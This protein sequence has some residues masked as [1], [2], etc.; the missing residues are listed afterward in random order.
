MILIYEC[1][2]LKYKKFNSLKININ[3][4]K[5]NFPNVYITEIEIPQNIFCVLKIKKMLKSS[6]Y[7]HMTLLDLNQKKNNYN[8]L[9]KNLIPAL[10]NISK[11]YG[12]DLNNTEIGIIIIEYN[13]DVYEMIEKVSKICRCIKIHENNSCNF[14]YD[15][16]CLKTGTCVTKG[17]KD[18]KIIINIDE[19]ISIITKSKTYFD[20]KLI[21]NNEK[22]GLNKELFDL[23]FCYFSK[24]NDVQE[25]INKKIVKKMVLMSK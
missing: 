24:E 22:L 15:K 25:L 23:I 14:P 19:E 1:V 18:E 4:F 2:V 3:E 6:K 17:N 7:K 12:Y 5:I 20:I 13:D 16:I 11:I 10:K 21:Y 9:K 8:L